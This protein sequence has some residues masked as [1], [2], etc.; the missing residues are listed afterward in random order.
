[1]PSTH[2][3][4]GTKGVAGVHLVVAQLSLRSCV[5]L[6]TTRNLKSVDIVAF[7]EAMNQFAFI[8]VKATDK[9]RGGWPVYTIQ[10]DE[11]WEQEVRQALG[12]GK[13]FFYVFVALPTPSQT[14][15]AYY[16]VPSAKLADMIIRDAKKWQ[17]ARPGRLLARSLC[18]WGF[19]A[20]VLAKDAKKYRD[21]WNLLRLD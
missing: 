21:R 11:G 19:D 18:A 12:K 14:A 6:P 5:A 17:A 10:K 3:T 15:A 4:K 9:P 7:N 13:S 2:F 20:S 8:Q 1:M 16:I